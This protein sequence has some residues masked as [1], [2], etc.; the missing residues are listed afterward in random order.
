MIQNS[1]II[2]CKYRVQCGHQNFLR[3]WGIGNYSTVIS[4]ESLLEGSLTEVICQILNSKVQNFKAYSSHSWS[5]YVQEAKYPLEG[6][7]KLEAETHL[8]VQLVGIKCIISYPHNNESA[9]KEIG[10]YNLSIQDGG[11][12]EILRWI[13]L[14]LALYAL[15]TVNVWT[16]YKW[17]QVRIIFI[18][19]KKMQ[20]KPLLTSPITTQFD[21]PKIFP[22]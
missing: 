7:S 19:I 3:I 8:N 11:T 10:T 18:K 16:S 6:E 15:H 20:H 22:E 17:D 2:R 1:T 5:S 12:H 4:M 14:H 9:K 21:P 13:H